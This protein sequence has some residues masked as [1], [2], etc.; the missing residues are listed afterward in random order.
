KMSSQ[1]NEFLLSQE[2]SND[3][4]SSSDPNSSNYE[5]I[6]LIGSGA[7][8]MVYKARDL[9]NEGQFVALKKIRIPLTEIGV[10]ISILREISVL[11]QLQSFD[12]PNVVRLLDICHGRNFEKQFNLFLVLEHVDQ[13]LSTYLQRCPSPGLSLDNI[14]DLMFQILTG[15]DFLHSNRI[16]HRDLK[17]ANILVTNKGQVK[18]ADFGLAR[19]Y[20]Q[21]Q[22]LTAVV[23]TLWYRA[24]EVLLQSSY[25][26]SVDV[27]SCGCIFAELYNKKPLF[28]GQSEND[29][30]FKIFDL[31]GSPDPSDWPD[32]H[33]LRFN[34][35][36]NFRKRDLKL[37]IKDVCD[38]GK[39]LFE[40]MLIFNPSKRISARQALDHEYFKD[41]IS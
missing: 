36:A 19:I 2:D 35:F 3:V 18:L 39:Q 32:D 25:S 13:D 26:S 10:P 28:P 23:V 11:K 38:D 22:P 30:L 31:I 4:S 40:K 29:Q 5:K 33:S 14:K 37:V 15:V 41:L 20:K 9:N 12:H 34:N 7:Y 8:G 6:A 24:P 27:W 21:T 1:N 17:P 16:V